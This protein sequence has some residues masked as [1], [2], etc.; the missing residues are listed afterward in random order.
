VREIVNR[1]GLS[2]DLGV[3]PASL[4]ADAARRVF[5]HSGHIENAARLIGSF[6]LDT[7]PPSSAIH[8][9]V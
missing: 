6:S 5:D 3:R 9:P 4:T 1:A 2:D 8:T 7:P